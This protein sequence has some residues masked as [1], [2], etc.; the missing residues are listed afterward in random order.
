MS[1]SSDASP[2]SSP[3]N[4]HPSQMEQCLILRT[5]LLTV[6][7]VRRYFRLWELSVLCPLVE[8][9]RL[10]FLERHWM[11]WSLSGRLDAIEFAPPLCRRQPRHRYWSGLLARWRGLTFGMSSV[12]V[13]VYWL[14]D[15]GAPSECHRVWW[16]R[17]DTSKSSLRQ[18]CG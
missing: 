1:L 10:S 2:S 12:L 5:R 18:G 4:A 9:M 16:R 13:R 11:A 3:L 8:K 15:E 6:Y 7:A 14:D 17:A